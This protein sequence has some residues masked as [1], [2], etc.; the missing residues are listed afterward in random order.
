MGRW[1]WSERWFGWRTAI[2][3]LEVHL[4]PVCRDVEDRACDEVSR[5]TRVRGQGR[6]GVGVKVGVLFRLWLGWKIG[7]RVRVR[8]GVSV[9]VGVSVR[10]SLEGM[11]DGEW[12]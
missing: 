9:G 10:M 6:V 3:L 5:R 2:H 7:L 8:F 1:R 11:G 12:W 4:G